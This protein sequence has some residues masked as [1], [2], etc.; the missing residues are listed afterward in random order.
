ME[1][2]GRTV[3]KIHDKHESSDGE[4]P[5]K[6]KKGSKKKLTPQDSQVKLQNPKGKEK[7]IETPR[8]KRKITGRGPAMQWS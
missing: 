7:T 6:S 4:N 8:Q 5:R 3:P 1:R 2:T